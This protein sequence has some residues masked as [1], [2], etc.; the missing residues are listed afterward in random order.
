LL[1]LGFAVKAG[2]LPFHTWLPHAHPAA[3][4]HISGSLCDIV[5]LELSDGGDIVIE[6]DKVGVPLDEKNIA[7]KAAKLFFDS[8]G[9]RSGV[10]IRI[11]KNIPMAAGLAGGSADGAAVLVGL[12]KLFEEPFSSTELC[13]IGAKLGAD[14]PFCVLCGCAYSEGR[15]DLPQSLPTLSRDMIF[16][17]ACGGEGVSTPRAY[18]MLDDAYNSFADYRPASVDNIIGAIGRN[19]F[20][21]LAGS[22]FNIFEAPISN[23][24]EAVGEIKRIMLDC[25]A[26]AAMMSGSGPSVFGMFEKMTDAEAAVRA[27]AQKNYFAAT[28]FPVDKRM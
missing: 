22:L 4:A 9:R 8:L 2:L 14:V 6:C 1:F 11:K 16:V 3:P 5:D 17:V 27:I 7:H 18:A 15:G 12:N 25:G 20:D 13:E 10:V 26:R 28:A 23:E 19:D 21:A 24:R